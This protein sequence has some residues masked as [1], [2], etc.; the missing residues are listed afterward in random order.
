MKSARPFTSLFRISSSK[1]TIQPERKQYTHS[2]EGGGRRKEGGGRREVRSTLA[3]GPLIDQPWR[4]PARGRSF[5]SSAKTS[6]QVRSVLA[7]TNQTHAGFEMGK[8]GKKHKI[9]TPNFLHLQKVEH[10]IEK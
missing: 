5:L 10:I 2:R 8:S 7:R 1:V 4:L 6:Q 9:K 3:V